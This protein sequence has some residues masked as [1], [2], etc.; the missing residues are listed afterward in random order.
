MDVQRLVQLLR[1]EITGAFDQIHLRE[2]LVD[3]L[4]LLLVD[5]AV[6]LGRGDHGANDLPR[7]PIRRLALELVE[8]LA[9][10]GIALTAFPRPLL[11]GLPRQPAQ[12]GDAAEPERRAGHRAA[13]ARPQQQG[14]RAGRERPL[15]HAVQHR[16]AL[17]ALGR[18]VELL[19]R[20]LAALFH[21]LA[22]RLQQLVQ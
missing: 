17:F 3:A 13:A 16:F 14:Q 2:L 1:N 11:I 9:R 22:P 5:V 19:L 8:R 18:D 10:R 21:P 20:Q 12:R 7:A 6:G 4:F 15:F